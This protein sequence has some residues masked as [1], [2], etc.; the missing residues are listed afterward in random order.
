[1][2]SPEPYWS[3]IG[4]LS[5]C[6]HWTNN[7]YDTGP[8]P[9]PLAKLTGPIMYRQYRTNTVAFIGPI[10]VLYSNVIWDA[11]YLAYIFFNIL[12]MMYYC[13]KRLVHVNLTN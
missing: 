11:Y 7:G 8:L 5:L 2:F 13:F 3:F 12:L 6:Q 4:P 1:M 10:M 9:Q